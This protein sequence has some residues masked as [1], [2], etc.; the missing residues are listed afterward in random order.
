MGYSRWSASDWDGYA[1]TTSATKPTVDHIYTSKALVLDLDPKGIKM[2]ESRDSDINPLSTAVIVALDVTGSMSPVLDS[3]ARKG[4]G[5]LC[6]EIYDR[7][8]V[9]DPHIMC[10]GL[11]DVAAFDKAPLQ[12]TQFEADIRIAEQLEKLY[13]E[14][15]GGGNDNESYTL[16]WFFAAHHTSTDCFEKRGKKGFL[17]TVGDEMPPAVLRADE[18]ERVLGYRPQA[19]LTTQE[20]YEMVSRTYHVFHVMIEEGDFFQRASKRVTEAWRNLL[21]QNALLLSDHTKL[22]ETI[23]SAIQVTAGADVDTVADSWDGTTALVIRK[24]ISGL[25]VNTPSATPG[26][27]VR[28]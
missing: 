22:G 7:K 5:V 6:G 3:I 26:G 19:D 21:G 28:F 17:F 10:M 18:V 16:P 11:G 14:G 13:L 15:G 12:V 27:V 20:L 2:R 1:A 24:A 8:P 25:G 23:V 4:L 9:T